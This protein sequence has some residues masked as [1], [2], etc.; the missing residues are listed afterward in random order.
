M[1]WLATNAEVLPLDGLLAGCG[2]RPL[3]AAIT[4]DDGYAS[5]A[6]NAEPILRDL[7]LPATIYINTGW[8]SEECR[9]DSAPEMGHYPGEQFMSWKDVELLTNRN[10]TIGSH[11]VEH[12]DLTGVDDVRRI[13][14]LRDSKQTIEDRLGFECRHFAYTWGR[15]TRQVKRAVADAGYQTAV[16]A[17]HGPVRQGS[18]LYALPRIDISNQYSLEDFQAIVRGE[19]DFLGGIQRARRVAQGMAW[20]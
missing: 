18:D 7:G 9:H 11:G 1:E 3:Q 10:W 14:E 6:L 13:Q 19:W 17:V 2:E 4:F 5:V 20:Q 16:S 12:V 15:Y 8:M